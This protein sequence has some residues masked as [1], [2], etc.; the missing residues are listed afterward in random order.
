MDRC[1]G[2][3]GSRSQGSTWERGSVQAPSKPARTNDDLE[4]NQFRLH[5]RLC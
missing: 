4:G 3:G 5:D 1:A 2:A